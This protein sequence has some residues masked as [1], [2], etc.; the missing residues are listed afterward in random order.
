MLAGRYSD[1]VANLD[2]VLK[3][4]DGE[5]IRV[6]RRGRDAEHVDRP[7]LSLCLAV[8][9]QV[10]ETLRDKPAMRGRGLAARFLY[11]VPETALGTRNLDPSPMGS[12]VT[13]AWSRL[14]RELARPSDRTDGTDGTPVL[15]MSAEALRLHAEF[16][17][18]IEPRLHPDSGD[19]HDLSDWAGKLAGNIARIAGLLH[20]AEHGW[21]G[22][23]V[24]VS[25]ETMAGAVEIGNYLIP[26]AQVAL[27]A[28]GRDFSRARAALH[29]L[30][31]SGLGT[32]SVRDAHRALQSGRFP[33][34]Q[35]VR[36][37]LDV[38]V[39][40]GHLRV[41]PQP[42]PGPKGGQP[43]SPRFAVHPELGGGS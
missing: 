29:W 12:T 1:G 19:L 36:A 13:E 2:G 32:V 20:L 18:M 28:P 37:T 33:D 24:A 15:V 5:S 3:A 34:A 21:Q 27:A 9:P 26:H 6:D 7:I 22:T 30:R 43:P 25:A 16:R 10:L 42:A 39:D 40:H 11:S 23:T 35:S 4:W 41:L 8:Q 31:G 17:A 38:L 14:L